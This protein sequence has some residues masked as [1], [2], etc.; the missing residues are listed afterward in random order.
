MYHLIEEDQEPTGVTITAP[1]A[2]A[3]SKDAVPFERMKF[4]MEETTES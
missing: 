3:G 4:H 2:W 1:L